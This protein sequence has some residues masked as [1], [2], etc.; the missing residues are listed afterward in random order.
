MFPIFKILRQYQSTSFKSLHDIEK[1]DENLFAHFKKDCLEEVK[2]MDKR[3]LETLLNRI[4][5][6]YI[7]DG[8]ATTKTLCNNPTQAEL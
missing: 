3:Q 8:E 1:E 7:P 6:L 4:A 2:N 5:Y